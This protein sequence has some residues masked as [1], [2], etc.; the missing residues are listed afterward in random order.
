M[1]SIFLFAILLI[2]RRLYSHS[3]LR[4]SPSCSFTFNAG[5]LNGRSISRF[6]LARAHSRITAL[7]TGYLLQIRCGVQHFAATTVTTATTGIAV[8]Q[9]TNCI[10]A[11]RTAKLAKFLI[12]LVR[13]LTRLYVC[14]AF[15]V[16]STAN[17]ASLLQLVA[18]TGWIR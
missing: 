1:F 8:G 9:C 12:V 16:S 6:S 3:K 14:H 11:D 13:P 7:R 15:S 4:L 10:I 2:L 17:T 18:A 5:P